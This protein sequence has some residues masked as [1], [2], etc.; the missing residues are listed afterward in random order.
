VKHLDWDATV[1]FETKRISARATWSIDKK[2]KNATELILDARSVNIVRVSLDDDL[3]TEFTLSDEDPILGQALRVQLLPNTTRVSVYYET[4]PGSEAL[5]WLS[6][7]QTAGKKLP[8]LFT[9]S[10][11]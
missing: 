5:Q 1:D 3:P 6:P 8:F 9:Q 4:I 10:Q 2:E 7:Q 11:A